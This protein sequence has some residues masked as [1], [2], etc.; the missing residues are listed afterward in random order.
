M[1]R[2]DAARE[3]RRR[4]LRLGRSRAVPP[5]RHSPH[6][7]ALVDA[8]GG[9]SLSWSLR[10]SL[11]H[12]GVRS[13]RCSAPPR[14][15]LAGSVTR[16]LAGRS[17]GASWASP[18]IGPRD[19]E[20]SIWTHRPG[21]TW[22]RRSSGLTASATTKRST[23]PRGARR[24]VGLARGRGRSRDGFFRLPVLLPTGVI[25]R[26]GRRF[27]HTITVAALENGCGARGHAQI[28]VPGRRRGPGRAADPTYYSLLR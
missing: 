3:Q 6:P 13:I 25:W 22:P 5:G 8:T 2:G 11:T 12:L 14:A 1:G 27:G 18:R 4:G 9:T 19:R 16:R 17:D 28:E 20:W 26:G 24:V 15:A 7:L 21:R 10:S 23:S